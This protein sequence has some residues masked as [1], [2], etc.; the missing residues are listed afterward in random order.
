[1]GN[2]HGYSETTESDRGG[3][4]VGFGLCALILV[5]SLRLLFCLVQP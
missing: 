3:P 1:M 4:L 5:S 2:C